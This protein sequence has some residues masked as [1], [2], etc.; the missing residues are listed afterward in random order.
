MD[1]TTTTF[2][3][4]YYEYEAGDDDSEKIVAVRLLMKIL[5]ERNI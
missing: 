4:E 5:I 1:T 3:T 2:E